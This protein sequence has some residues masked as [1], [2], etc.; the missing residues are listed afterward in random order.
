MWPPQAFTSLGLGGPTFTPQGTAGWSLASLLALCFICEPLIAGDPRWWGFPASPSPAPFLYL[1][2]LTSP[3]FISKAETPGSSVKART[4]MPAS[5]QNPG[6]ENTSITLLLSLWKVPKGQLPV[7]PQDSLICIAWG[8]L[9]FHRIREKIPVVLPRKT[10][11]KC[12]LLKPDK[13]L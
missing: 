11:K 9:A 5:A 1:I 7:T 13:Q 12:I 3:Y 4:R 6:P 8:G 2:S 10:D